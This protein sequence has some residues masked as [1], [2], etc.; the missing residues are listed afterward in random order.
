MSTSQFERTT[1]IVY[2]S[3]S[4]RRRV[5]HEAVGR[6]CGT[7]DILGHGGLLAGLLARGV[8]VRERLEVERRGLNRVDELGGR[9]RIDLTP[10]RRPDA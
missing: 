2:K 3:V 6:H 5:E 8:G 9:S 4:I 10:S 7:L 1:A